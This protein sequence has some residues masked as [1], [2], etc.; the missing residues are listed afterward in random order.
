MKS[1]SVVPL[2]RVAR[3]FLLGLVAAFA[4]IAGGSVFAEERV[5][6]KADAPTPVLV[7]SMSDVYPGTGF[8]TFNVLSTD[9]P[10][11]TLTLPKKLLGIQWS[12]TYYPKTIRDAVELCYYRPFS[13][14]KTCQDIQPSSSG[15]LDFFNDQA[16]GHGSKVVINHS[17]LGGEPPFARPAGVD[18]VTFKYQY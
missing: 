16:F 3:G 17:V 8:S 18:S 13:S 12:T 15:T 2:V 9:I 7:L 4:A 11:G 1:L 10:A 14:E 5:L 6:T